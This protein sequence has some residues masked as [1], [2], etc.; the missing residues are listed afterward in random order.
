MNSL[1]PMQSAFTCLPASA[2]CSPSDIKA[3]TPPHS[4]NVGPDHDSAVVSGGPHDSYLTWLTHSKAAM[5][6]VR[7]GV[8]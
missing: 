6:L 8:L 3:G 7:G 5:R 4:V 2:L 1:P